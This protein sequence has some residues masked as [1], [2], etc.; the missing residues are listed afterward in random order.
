MRITAITVPAFL[1][2][3]KTGK[4]VALLFVM[5]LGLAVA[6]PSYAVDFAQ[7]GSIGGPLQDALTQLGGLSSGVKALIGFIG[8]VVALISLAGLRNMAPVLFFIGLAIFAAVGLTIAGTI[9]G[10]QVGTLAAF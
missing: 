4:G 6:F 2:V 8:F 7:L 3:G 5:L 9:M 1:P 10:A